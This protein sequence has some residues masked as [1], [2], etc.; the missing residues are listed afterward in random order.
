[1]TAQVVEAVFFA[2]YTL[3]NFKALYGRFSTD[4]YSKDFLQVA[5]GGGDILGEVLPAPKTTGAKTPVEYV[6]PGGTSPD[7]KLEYGG[8]WHLRWPTAAK[9][10][11][12]T[13][14]GTTGPQQGIP[15]N[16]A[17]SDT[18]G[19]DSEYAA[20]QASGIEPWLIA[21]KLAGEVRRL[22]V[23]SYF[24]NPPAGM[25]ERGVATLPQQV[26]DGITSIGASEGSDA[27]RLPAVGRPPL[28]PK[29]MRAKK[30]VDD[31]RAAL[32]SGDNVLLVGPPGTGKSVAL[33]DLRGLYD[34]R[35]PAG[36][37]LFDPDLWYE[38]WSVAGPERRSELLIFHPS[39]G[40]E[41]FV[42]GLYPKSN[43]LGGVELVGLPGPLLS[44]SHWIGDS[45]RQAL[46]LLD[47]FNRGQ[48]AAIFGD[49]LALMDKDKR[50][51]G[52]GTGA[53]IPRPY[54]GQSMEVPATYSYV[55]GA[56][57]ETVADEVGLP[58]G[59]HIV[60]AMNST[61][62][63]VAPLDAAMR[64]R[65]AVIRVGPDYEALQNH[66]GVSTS[67]LAQPLPFT[68]DVST[69]PVESV[70]SLAVQVLKALNSRIEF[71][72]GEDFLLGHA[73]VWGVSADSAGARFAEL[74]HAFDTKL[75]STLKMTFTD[76][77][78]ALGAILGVSDATQY[79]P[80]QPEPTDVVAFWKSAP[81]GLSLF[82]QKRLVVRPLGAA[83]VAE[84]VR[85]L[86]KL[87]SL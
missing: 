29:A 8:R 61:D 18:T 42:A 24:T 53:S 15:G 44:L 46:L 66:L 51:S 20:I 52:K 87:A 72:L 50:S 43:G 68:D 75:V 40:Y 83:G 60:A 4:G 74:V 35:T 65:F 17:H 2:K 7:G 71:C 69:W 33:D 82:V 25:L 9:P 47:E 34:S 36:T 80:N 31:I 19:A 21:V 64:R 3:S 58:R 27:V 48:A 16:P 41:N 59:L 32:A 84:Q 67:E 11:P 85:A 30:V 79:A 57:G 54:P 55:A 81:N 12:W 1:M 6:W 78:E 86:R 77:D 14:T 26:Q 5:T 73:L 45:D 63:S 13:V 10:L 56:S 49:T 37:L 22:H 23:R 39:Y 28:P 76:Q 62:R 38:N 70:S